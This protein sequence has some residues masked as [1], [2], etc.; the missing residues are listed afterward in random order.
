[1]E[2]TIEIIKMGTEHYDESMALSQFA[3]QYKKIN[4]FATFLKS[5]LDRFF[6]DHNSWLKVSSHCLAKDRLFLFC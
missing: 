2:N 3:F 4:M 5:T 1:M 6:V